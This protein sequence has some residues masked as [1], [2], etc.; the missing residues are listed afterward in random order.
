MVNKISKT[1]KE[2][3]HFRNEM[4]KYVILH[5]NKKIIDRISENLENVSK[6]ENKS[7]YMLS[8]I[9]N[10]KT[11]TLISTGMGA[12]NT[13]IVV[14]QTIEQGAEYIFKLGTF[15]A[16]QEDIEIGDIYICQLE[17]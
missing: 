15:G 12:G 13:A 14:D 10:N 4:S 2:T 9:Y 3:H 11:V 5:H 7:Y 6:V 8:G 17:R 16:L 1:S